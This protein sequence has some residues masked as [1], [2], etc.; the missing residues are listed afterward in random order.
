[1]ILRIRLSDEW[2]GAAA[3]L[4]A[5]LLWFPVS[6]Q[7]SAEKIQAIYDSA[8]AAVV[9][10]KVE[11][12]APDD[13][14]KRRE[15]SGFFIYS[16]QNRSFLLTA[17]HVLGSSE[18]QQNQNPDWKVENG[19]VVR[20]I[21]IDSLDER[22]A[23]VLRSEEVLVAPTSPLGIDIVL[24]MVDQGRYPTLEIANQL[25]EKS[26]LSDVVLLGFREG[27]SA[28]T[29]PIPAAIGSLVGFKYRTSIPSQ[30]GESGGPWIDLKSGRVFALAS[31]VK[32]SPSDPSNEATPVVLIKSTL[33]DYFESAGL[34]LD[35]DPDVR[36][37]SLKILGSDGQIRVAASG[38][39][40]TLA[41]ALRKEG[42]FGDLVEISGSGNEASQCDPGS[43]RT[44]SQ[45]KAVGKVS[46]FDVSGMRFEFSVAAQG[47]HFRRAATCLGPNLVGISGND[48][49]ATASVGLDGTLSFNAGSAPIA[50]NWDKMPAAGAKFKVI[51]ET[52]TVVANSDISNTGQLLLK[53]LAPGNYRFVTSVAA[54]LTNQGACCGATGTTN[55]TVK[56]SAMP[57]AQR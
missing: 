33:R 5:V 20:K 8:K 9:K 26:P 44:R 27:K 30:P 15:G 11:G 14:I 28:L 35:S 50:I 31:V 7:T 56:L 38:D 52:G 46:A 49:K 51:N 45:A 41:S 6:A 54:E 53:N 19:E 32:N 13:K 40:G 18:T 34:A 48:T 16:D 4:A 22:G 37:A 2:I 39:T 57:L 42:G 47:G 10:I 3:F 24:L 55:G 12:T 21:R 29:R 17:R 43:G 36:V 1:M 23:L 25:A